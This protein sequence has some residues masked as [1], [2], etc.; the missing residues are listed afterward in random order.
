MERR[1][2]LILLSIL[3]SPISSDFSSDLEKVTQV[4]NC[5]PYCTFN[6]S[7]ITSKTIALF[8]KDCYA[9]CGILVFNENTDIEK[10]E[11]KTLFKGMTTLFGS[12]RFENTRFQNFDFFSVDPETHIFDF[13]CATCKFIMYLRNQIKFI[14]VGLSIVNNSKLTNIDFLENLFLST[15]RLTNE[16][17]LSIENNP[18]LDVSDLCQDRKYKHMF[19]LKT[20]GNFKDCGCRGDT[21]TLENMESFQNCTILNGGLILSYI[22]TDTQLTSLSRVSLVRGDVE[23]QKTN[24]KN[25]S[26]L[27]NLK[28]ILVKHGLTNEKVVLNI[29]DNS[30]MIRFGIPSL[31]SL[32]DVLDGPFIMNLE[33][34]HSEFCLTFEEVQFFLENYVSFNKI[35]AKF[36]PGAE[37]IMIDDM[38]RRVCQFK[39]MKTLAKSCIFI[40]GTVV[41]DSGDEEYVYKLES[42]ETIFGSIVIKNTK[43][44]NLNFLEKLRFIASLEDGYVMEILSNQNLTTAYF[45]DLG[46]I[47]SQGNRYVVLNDNP[48]LITDDCVIFPITYQTNVAFI[49]NNC[50]NSIANGYKSET[51]SFSMFIGTFG[52]WSLA[53]KHLV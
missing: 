25:L 12:L 22:D 51:I 17:T 16:C 28:R 46:N 36:C 8:P 48:L 4:Y 53:M 21:I 44:E 5:D 41:I 40:Y 7:E 13:Y 14:P 1:N 23:I 30:E 37:S 32:Y 43:L 9:V 47:I 38:E 31:T 35:H 34:L 15:D 19:E 2:I 29:H 45:P 50:E 20:I 52:L 3:I 26:F 49:G 11:I 39:N 42:L 24:F 6:E 18:K 10:S 27:K 33:N